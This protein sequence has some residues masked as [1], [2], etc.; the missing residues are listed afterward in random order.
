MRKTK[1]E[2]INKAYKHLKISGIT[3]NPSPEDIEDGLEALEDMMYEFQTQIPTDYNFEDTP[4]ANTDSGVNPAYNS[5]VA[6]NLAVRLADYFG[7]DIPISLA[8]NAMQSL[9]NWFARVAQVNQILPSRTMPRG[10]GNTTRFPIGWR[11]SRYEKGNPISPSTVDILVGETND[12]AYDFSNYLNTGEVVSSYSITTQDGYTL[13][14]DSLAGSIVSYSL[15]GTG[16]S[17]TFLTITITT[18]LGRE[19]PQRININ[20]NEV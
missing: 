7:K 2:H 4:D 19:L 11:Y 3:A 16:A 12:F 13:A 14:S 8:M 5:A 6:T 17:S 15:T 18:D 1:I 9:S 10:S 20:V